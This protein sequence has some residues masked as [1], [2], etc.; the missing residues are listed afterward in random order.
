[1]PNIPNL[2]P[3][4]VDREGV[5]MTLPPPTLLPTI[6]D[7]I[8]NAAAV[9]KPGERGR[10]VWIADT[11]GVNVAVVNKV[12]EHIEIAAFVGKRWGQP[13]AAGLVGQI[14]W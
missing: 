6:R 7:Y 8:D 14:H 1:M 3:E 12:N 9:L 10:L 5:E 2:P 13:Y 11:H 4:L